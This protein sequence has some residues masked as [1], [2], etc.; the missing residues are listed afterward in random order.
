MNATMVLVNAATARSKVATAFPLNLLHS[1]RFHQDHPQC[2][3]PIPQHHLNHRHNLRQLL[4]QINHRR[5]HRSL[6]R[7]RAH[8]HFHRNLRGNS[9]LQ[10]NPPLVICLLRHAC[11][12]IP[13]HSP[14]VLPYPVKK[15]TTFGHKIINFGAHK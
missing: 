15:T 13:T 9:N 1:R 4:L 7:H 11:T 3:R 8:P 5:C 2:H 6:L 14:S 12:W 10:H